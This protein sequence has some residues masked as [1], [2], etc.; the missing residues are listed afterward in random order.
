MKRGINMIISRIKQVYL[1]IFCKFNDEVN[2]EIKN[3]LSEDEFLIF[4]K[5]SDYDKL[6]SYKLFQKVKENIFLKDKKIFFKLALLHDSGKGNIG[7][8]RRIKKVLIGDK[9]L[10]RHPDLAFEKLKN[11]NLELA[12]LCR[13]HHNKNVND[14]MKIFQQLDDE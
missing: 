2:N 8:I 12:N 14:D 13:E 9:I 3:I 5:M 4:N 1:Y 11:I 7:L 10:E 6:H